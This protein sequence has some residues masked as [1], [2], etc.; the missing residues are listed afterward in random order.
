MVL[1]NQTYQF[2]ACRCTSQLFFNLP[3]YFLNSYLSLFNCTLGSVKPVRRREV[4]AV[5]KVPHTCP[6]D[7]CASHLKISSSNMNSDCQLLF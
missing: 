6:N 5:Q 3:S 7:E 1:N 2:I 4:T